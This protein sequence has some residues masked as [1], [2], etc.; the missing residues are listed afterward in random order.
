MYQ[1]CFQGINIFEYYEFYCHDLLIGL[2][3]LVR[4]GASN[5]GG[6]AKL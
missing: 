2:D 5:F 4:E 3:F 6:N 1:I